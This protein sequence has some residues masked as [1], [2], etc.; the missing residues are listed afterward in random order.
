MRLRPYGIEVFVAL[1]VGGVAG[2]SV[3]DVIVA[4]DTAQAMG[5]PCADSLDCDPV[6]FCAKPSCAAAQ[7]Q[8]QLRPVLC[9]DQSATTC[10]CSDGVN[11]WNDCLRQQ[12]GIAASSK[13]E[14]RTQYASCGGY[15]GKACP[16]PGA[17][18]AKLAPGSGG[19]CD[20]GLAGVCWVLPP[21]CPA[22]AGGPLVQSCGQ[23]PPVC[24]DVCEAIRS[25]TP[26]R[27][28]FGPSC[29]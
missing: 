17:L 16:T 2:C 8:C 27:L 4:R 7:G 24:V 23:R 26:F 12:N 10:G 22:D 5:G 3:D 11:Y 25:E 29:P 20:P 14:C 6:A 28:P 21:S 15:R 13:G 9:D 19:M 18:C 1:S